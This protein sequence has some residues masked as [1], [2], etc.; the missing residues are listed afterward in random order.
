MKMSAAQLFDLAIAAQTRLNARKYWDKTN[1]PTY[2]DQ[3]AALKESSTVYIGNLSY[4]TSEQLVYE[5]SRQAGP[6]KRVSFGACMF[7]AK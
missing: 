7:L 2:E 1:F 6:I 4:Y 3:L 5:L